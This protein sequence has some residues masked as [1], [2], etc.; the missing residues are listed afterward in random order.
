[1]LPW[2]RLGQQPGRVSQQ[3]QVL[4]FPLLPLRLGVDTLF[5]RGPPVMGTQAPVS[6]RGGAALLSG[7]TRVLPRFL[8]F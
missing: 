7:E 3:P 2:H 8:S 4:D 1:M 6:G 5:S